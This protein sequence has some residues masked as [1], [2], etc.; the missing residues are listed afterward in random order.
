ME[1][2]EFHKFFNLPKN[3]DNATNKELENVWEVFPKELFKSIRRQFKT[4]EK[5]IT[6]T[7][8]KN[9]YLYH[10]TES[11]EFASNP[12]ASLNFKTFFG[13]F[14]AVAFWFS[15]RRGKDK[16]GYLIQWQT[17]CP[18][19]VTIVPQSISS[20][21]NKEERCVPDGCI[22]RMVTQIL[23]PGKGGIRTVSENDYIELVLTDKALLE[24]LIPLRSFEIDLN[25]LRKN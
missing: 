3:L 21:P 4:D 10:G 7:I 22:G 16:I 13:C 9:T 25:L 23:C 15:L 19:T 6:V 1:E 20:T 2:I 8:P 12:K 14:P 5:S 24:C 17:T 18:L 11:A